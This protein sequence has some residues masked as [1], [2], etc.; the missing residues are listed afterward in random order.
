MYEIEYGAKCDKARPV[1]EDARL[2]RAEIKDLKK[3]GQLPTDWQYSVR[4][5]P[6]GW[7]RSIEITAKSPR[8]IYALDPDCDDLR[9]HPETGAIVGSAWMDKMTVEARR[10]HDILNAMHRAYNYDGSDVITDYF[11][12]KFY[13]TVSVLRMEGVPRYLGKEISA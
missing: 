4:M 5:R 9:K 11:N 10:V 13:G 2:M 3:K 7:T 1:K 6:G 8:P 12:V